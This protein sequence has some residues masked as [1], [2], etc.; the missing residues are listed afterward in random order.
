MTTTSRSLTGLS[1]VEAANRRAAGQGNNI[2]LK[3]SRTYRDIFRDN[4]FTFINGVYFFLSL[5]LLV[6]ERVSDVVVVTAI[7]L[8]NVVINIVQ[9]IRAKQKLDNIALLTRPRATVIRAGQELDIDLGEIVVGDVLVVRPGDQIAVDGPVLTAEEIRVDESLLTGE[10]DLVPKQVG[11]SL[12]SGSFCASGTAC[13]TADKVGSES[14]ASKMTAEARQFRKVLTPLQRH[15]NTLIRLLL[16]LAIVLGLITL[17][18]M[19][20]GV[21]SFTSGIQNLVVI[22]GLVPVGLYF[23]ITLTY[24]LGAVNIANQSALVQQANAVESISNVDIMCIDKTGTL[25]ANRIFLQT[26]LPLGA[27][28]QSELRRLLGDYAASAAASNK[29][30]DALLQAEP[31]PRR[32]VKREIPFNSAYKWS[33]LAFEESPGMYILGAPE[34]LATAVPDTIAETLQIYITDGANQGLRVLLFAHSATVVD[35]EDGEGNPMLPPLTPLAMLYFGDEL[36]EGVHQTLAEFRQAGVQVK[37]ISGDNPATVAAL[38]KQAGLGDDILAVSGQALA[39]MDKV[40]FNQAA[41][42]N[43]IFGR[44]TPEQ[45]ARLV[46]SF[47][48]R[49]HYVAMMGD[50][51][52]DVLSLKQANVGVAME[53][54][55][56]AT[57]SV[58]DIVLLHDSFSALPKIFLEGQRIRNGVADITKLFMVRIFA[59]S[60]VIV[61]IGMITLSF[62]IGIKTGTIVTFFTVGI[63]P[64]FVTLWAK[65]K[66]VKADHGDPFLHF[67]LPATITLSLV[68]ILLYLLFLAENIGPI[69][70]WLSGQLPLEEV[71]RQITREQVIRA[72]RIAETALVTMQIFGGLLLLPFLKPPTRTWVGGAPLSRDW[73][74]TILAVVLMLA[75]GVIVTVPGLRNFFEIYPLQ[76]H[77]YAGIVGLA[78]IWAVVLRFTWR[79]RLLDRFLGIPISPF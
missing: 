8:L 65:S 33:G 68:S 69:L 46:K 24:A 51:V 23:M 35:Q 36:R 38:A 44:I 16:G 20:L 41:E 1:Q 27:T 14:L 61:A 31:R 59:F 12:Y 45:K 28:G 18:R 75:Y 55:S 43:T 63:P 47:Q 10:S 53:S 22:V 60:V 62:P 48:D 58:A 37:V 5:V 50:G 39:A 79:R 11:D 40:V 13:Y 76:S 7:V 25:T 78:I 57:R 67:V 6:L 77:E 19:I 66:P 71:G 72:Q 70:A 64:F 56:Q 34:V 2:P 54:G 4:L 52:N 29:T 21:S 74:F 73:R 49:G 17:L 3:T 32:S 9:E 30:N 15:I 26:V 42:E